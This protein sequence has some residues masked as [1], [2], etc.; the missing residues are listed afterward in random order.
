[1]P[2]N[3]PW[4][5]NTEGNEV[6]TSFNTKTQQPTLQQKCARTTPFTDIH[7]AHSLLKPGLVYLFLFS[8]TPA[9]D[10]IN[11]PTTA[12]EPDCAPWANF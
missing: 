5:K 4:K 9:A 3:H 8:Q 7:W 11:I 12:T 10:D 1:M 2:Q 6:M